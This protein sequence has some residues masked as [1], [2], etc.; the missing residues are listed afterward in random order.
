MTGMIVHFA[1]KTLYIPV[2]SKH[3]WE[4]PTQTQATVKPMRQG[5]KFQ[6]G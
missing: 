5:S 4:K 2:K 3:S 1:P 6:S